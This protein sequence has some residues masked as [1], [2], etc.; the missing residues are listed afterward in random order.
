MPDANTATLAW[1]TA[2]GFTVVTGSDTL[3]PWDHLPVETLR[4]FAPYVGIDASGKT[5]NQLV[6]GIETALI[7]LMKIEIEEFDAIA[8]VDAGTTADPKYAVN[9]AKGFATSVLQLSKTEARPQYLYHLGLIPIHTVQLRQH[10]IR[11]RLH[12]ARSRC[13][14]Q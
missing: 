2:K 4:I 6:S 5:K 9:E 12:L 8:N 14:L 1:F 11:L 3:S 10:L 13:L 7:T